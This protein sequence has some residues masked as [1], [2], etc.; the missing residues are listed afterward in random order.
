MGRKGK[1]NHHTAKELQRKIDAHKP[2]GMGDRS[3]CVYTTE[4]E[5]VWGK[6]AVKL[7]PPSL[8]FVA[9]SP[10]TVWFTGSHTTTTQQEEERLVLPSASR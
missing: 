4:R 8:S 5:C 10:L 2:R 6:A 1:K 7:F 3:S 9:A